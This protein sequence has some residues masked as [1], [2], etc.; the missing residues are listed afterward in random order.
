VIQTGP[1][2]PNVYRSVVQVLVENRLL[3]KAAE[4][5]RRAR[6]ACKDPRLFTLELAQ[7][8]ANTMDYAGSTREFLA[9]LEQ[10]PAQLSFVQSRMSAFTV[11]ED[12][13]SAARDVVRE[14]LSTKEEP[15]LY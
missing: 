1:A 12:A 15:R 7:L 11:K 6:V 9:W 3:E 2:N 5:Y 14:T 4:M 10:N 13:R 8:L